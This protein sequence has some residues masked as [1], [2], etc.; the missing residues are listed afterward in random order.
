MQRVELKIRKEIP[1]LMGRG[2]MW[3]SIITIGAAIF[4]LVIASAV[5]MSRGASAE[6]STAQSYRKVSIKFP[7]GFKEALNAPRYGAGDLDGASYG[8]GCERNE[9]V[10]TCD[11]NTSMSAPKGNV[12]FSGKLTLGPANNTMLFGIKRKS[13]CT[14]TITT[15]PSGTKGCVYYGCLGYKK[16]VTMICMLKDPA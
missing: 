8:Y 9:V 12:L 6:N 14:A 15:D 7:Q 11:A 10:K 2:K 1:S 5:L 3:S 13:V 4:A 16:P